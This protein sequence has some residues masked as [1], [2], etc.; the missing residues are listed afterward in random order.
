MALRRRALFVAF[1][2]VRSVM[3]TYQ[4]V[5]LMSADRNRP[6]PQYKLLNDW[7]GN[8]ATIDLGV[9]PYHGDANL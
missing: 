1:H 8:A 4:D 3:V 5:T 7:I 9:V 2:G 6:Y